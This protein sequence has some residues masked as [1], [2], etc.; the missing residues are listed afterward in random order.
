MA[1]T[2]IAFAKSQTS[3]T[4][5]GPAHQTSPRKTSP[6]RMYSY[7]PLIPLLKSPPAPISPCILPQRRSTACCCTETRIVFQTALMSSASLIPQL[8]GRCSTRSILDSTAWIYA[9]PR[10]RRRCRPPRQGSSS[11]QPARLRHSSY[12]SFAGD[13]ARKIGWIR[14]LGYTPLHSQGVNADRSDR[15]VRRKKDNKKPTQL[16]LRS[17]HPYTALLLRHSFPAPATCRFKVPKL[18]PSPFADVLA[19]QGE[20]QRLFTD[21]HVSF[22]FP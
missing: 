4:Q 21:F 17:F 22:Y 16:L 13:V 2:I 20:A 3:P 12:L 18:I 14:Q 9:S 1:R 10:S 8:R 6:S 5:P 19:E 7:A 15:Q 11:K